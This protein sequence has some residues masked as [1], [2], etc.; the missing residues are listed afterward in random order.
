M[1]LNSEILARR[2]LSD[3]ILLQKLGVHCFVL[4]RSWF[5]VTKWVKPSMGV[6]NLNTDGCSKG[7]PGPSGGGS[8]LRDFRGDLIWAQAEFYG[9]QTNMVAEA[10]A[11]C[12][13]LE[14]VEQ[15]G[16]LA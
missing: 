11:S 6:V 15:R 4:P 10:K 2:C 9:Q 5:L 7:N 8:V 13:G 12:R 3:N 14:D 16:G 1:F